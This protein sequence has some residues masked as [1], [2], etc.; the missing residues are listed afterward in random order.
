MAFSSSK[1]FNFW[2]LKTKQEFAKDRNKGQGALEY[3]LLL[4]LVSGIAMGSLWQFNDAFAKWANNYFG[5]YLACLLEYGELPSLGG[6]GGGEA[7]GCD[8]EFEE[9]SLASG[10]PAKGFDGIDDEKK[11][12]DGDGDSGGRNS[13]GTSGSGSSNPSSAFGSNSGRGNASGGGP[14]KV[15]GGAAEEGDEDIGDDGYMSSS[16][17]GRGNNREDQ[18]QATNV[19]LREGELAGDAKKEKKA[20]VKKEVES[21]SSTLRKN[22]VPVRQPSA[23]T[24]TNVEDEEIDLGLGGYVRMLLIIAIVIALI[25]LLGSQGLQISKEWD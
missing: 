13:A 5:N 11:A 7:L 14:T 2:R 20:I 17:R 22:S 25:I 18:A 6:G 16:G 21:G 24:K 19:P 9:F 15:G 4:V 12:K 10:R 8:S 23:N 3:I 1:Y